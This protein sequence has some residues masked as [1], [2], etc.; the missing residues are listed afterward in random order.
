MK[1][2]EENL[3][4][5]TD[6]VAIDQ[7]RHAVSAGGRMTRKRTVYNL[8]N[9]AKDRLSDYWLQYIDE[10]QFI[11]LSGVPGINRFEVD[12]RLTSH[13]AVQDRLH[14]GEWRAAFRMPK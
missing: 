14:L 3:K 12:S 5:Y 6:E 11:Y 7:T 13:L 1:G 4:F 10:M 2:K 8:R 9:A